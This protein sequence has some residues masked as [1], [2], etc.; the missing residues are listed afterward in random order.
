[1]DNARTPSSIAVTRQAGSFH[2]RLSRRG[3]DG[4][5]SLL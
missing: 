1:M 2:V 5:Q 3:S 4:D